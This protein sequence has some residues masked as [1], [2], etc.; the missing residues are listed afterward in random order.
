MSTHFKFVHE[1][2]TD[3]ERFWKVFFHE[4]YNVEM[5]DRIGVKERRMLER[6]EE[7]DTIR[8]KVRIMPKRDLP[9]FVQ[10]I[11][12]GDLGYVEISTW[13]R[14][15][16]KIDVRVEPTLMKE[17]TKIHGIYTLTPIGPGRVRRVFEGDLSVSIPLVG[18]K[19]EGFIISDM[20]KSYQVAAQVTAEWLRKDF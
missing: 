17:K 16:N 8:W 7:G 10:K 20:E 9:G 2:D 12:G 15:D 14:K 11:V 4:P 6:R 5:Y 13:S 19:I 18:G 1:F 3:P